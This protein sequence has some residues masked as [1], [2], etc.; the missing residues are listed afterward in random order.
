[1][2]NRKINETTAK[3]KGN[4]SMLGNSKT[5]SA[6]ASSPEIVRHVSTNE[7]QP[8]INLAYGMNPSNLNTEIENDF[9]YEVQRRFKPIY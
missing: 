3:K 6:D 1:M 9:A 8:N 5:K 2:K 4:Q 7:H